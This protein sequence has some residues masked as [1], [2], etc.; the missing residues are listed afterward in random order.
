MSGP[1]PTILAS[2]NIQNTFLLTLSLTPASVNATTTAEQS[3]TVSGLLAGDQVSGVS[4]VG[5]WPNLTD[6]IN[7]RVISNNTLAVT[8]QNGTAGALVPPAGTYLVEINRPSAGFTMTA[9]P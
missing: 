9:I 2:G 7:F 8:F 6:M 3:F 4:Y 1:G 5:V